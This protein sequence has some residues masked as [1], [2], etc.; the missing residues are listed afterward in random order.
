LVLA[1]IPMEPGP[2]RP[3]STQPEMRTSALGSTLE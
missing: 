1:V 2:V 3:S